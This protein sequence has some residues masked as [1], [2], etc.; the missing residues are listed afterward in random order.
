MR[1]YLVTLLLAASICYVVTPFVRTWAIRFGVVAKMGW[2]RDV[3]WHGGHLRDGASLI[4]R[5]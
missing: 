4:A 1:E 3:D 2:P 5:R